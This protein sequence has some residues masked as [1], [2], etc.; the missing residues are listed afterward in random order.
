MGVSACACQAWHAYP[1]R[2]CPFFGLRDIK[3]A[4]ADGAARNLMDQRCANRSGRDHRC[5]QDCSRFLHGAAAPIAAD[6]LGVVAQAKQFCF[7]DRRAMLPDSASQRPASPVLLTRRDAPDDAGFPGPAAAVYR[8][9]TATAQRRRFAWR[10]LA[11][12]RMPAIPSR[13]RRVAHGKLLPF[14]PA[15]ARGTP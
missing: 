1:T 4:H 6:R 5:T 10:A 9:G 8:R 11:E 7:G 14:R 15:L 2:I 12:A 3:R 13:A